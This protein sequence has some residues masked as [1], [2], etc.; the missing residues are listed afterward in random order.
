VI[1][2]TRRIIIALVAIAALLI[3]PIS[4]S[5]QGGGPPSGDGVVAEFVRSAKNCDAGILRLV[6]I[7][8]SPKSGVYLLW[9]KNGTDPISA[10]D[11][12][13]VY[14]PIIRATGGSGPHWQHRVDAS[15]I[16]LHFPKGKFYLYVSYAYETANASHVTFMG[17]AAVA[18]CKKK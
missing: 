14:G 11:K 17:N 3:A 6:G 9:A 10:P 12:Q 2:M 18:A 1:A 7:P 4:A 16:G 15:K 8:P 13:I 5:A